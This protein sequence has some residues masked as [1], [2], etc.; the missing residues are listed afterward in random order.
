VPKKGLY[1]PGPSAPQ[2]AAVRALRALLAERFASVAEAFVHF[3]HQ[4]A[5]ALS[6]P[7]LRRG[8]ERLGC[9]DLFS[10]DL[11]PPPSLPY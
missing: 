2:V 3:D 5:R 9:G 7:L 6:A 10:M 11:V 4:G 1:K 8:L